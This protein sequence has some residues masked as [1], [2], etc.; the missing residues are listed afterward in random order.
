LEDRGEKLI[1]KGE[2]STP[3]IKK[4]V[5]YRI[6]VSK[7]IKGGYYELDG[8]VYWFSLDWGRWMYYRKNRWWSGSLDRYGYEK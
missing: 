4:F 7:L 8:E 6:I 1:I 2:Y 3:N 5:E